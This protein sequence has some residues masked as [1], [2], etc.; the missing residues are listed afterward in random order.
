MNIDL[1]Q[2]FISDYRSID[3]ELELKNIE[4]QAKSICR[5]TQ[6]HLLELS[7]ETL[8]DYLS[9]LWSM[10]M[11]GN[12]QYFVD[13]LIDSNGLE[14]LRTQLAN[15]IYGSGKLD[16][17]WD[18]FRSKIK[19]IGPATMSELLGKTFPNKYLI[20]TSKTYQGLNLLDISDSPKSA[21]GLSGQSYLKLCEIGHQL[22][23]KVQAQVPSVTNLLRLN[24]FIWELSRTNLKLEIDRTSTLEEAKFLHNDIRDKIADI[25]RW[26]GFKPEV[27]KRVGQGAVVDA[28]WE[29]TIGNMGRVIYVFEVQT[30]GSIDS[31]ILNLMR[32]KSNKAVQGIVA[33]TDEEQMRKIEGEISTLSSIKDEIKFWDYRD[34]LQVHEQLQSVNE[35][36]NKL[37]LVPFGL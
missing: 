9:P 27:E 11:W 19:G 37:G 25:G 8:L 31:L 13:D 22:L 32:A 7:A 18:E 4:K 36:I 16:E 15:L 12:K 2:S 20:C 1:L 14:L 21:S 33:V 5:Y 23:E 6:K 35:S 26:L 28:V 34:V 3:H 29:V 10:A 17:R 24:S 30:S